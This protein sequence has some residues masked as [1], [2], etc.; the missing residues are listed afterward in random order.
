MVTLAVPGNHFG[1]CF[2][3]VTKGFSQHSSPSMHQIKK[4]LQVTH[5][6]SI[7]RQDQPTEQGWLDVFAF[8]FDC[9]ST[10]M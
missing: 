3:G 7:V 9:I 1:S 10:Q 2:V 6:K 4:W 8:C 5:G